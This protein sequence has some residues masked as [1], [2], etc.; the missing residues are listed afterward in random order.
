MRIGFSIFQLIFWNYLARILL[1]FWSGSPEQVFLG[2]FS[3]SVEYVHWWA[4][5]L[6][7]SSLR[8]TMLLAQSLRT[9]FARS[10]FQLDYAWCVILQIP[11]PKVYWIRRCFDNRGL[12]PYSDS[13]VE[14]RFLCV[15][16]TFIPVMSSWE[17]IITNPLRPS[18]SVQQ[19][20]RCLPQTQ[21]TMCCLATRWV[22]ALISPQPIPP[23]ACSTACTAN[24]LFFNF[25]Y[26][27][28]IVF[29]LTERF[30]S[31]YLEHGP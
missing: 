9:Q 28:R 14:L 24:G 29:P 4:A 15:T 20:T 3:I 13:R 16:A 11:A 8:A 19:F 6:L 18:S 26:T 23:V 7:R 30:I 10:Q 2:M 17:K 12:K 5:K 22:H 27:L 21:T 25:V 31:S 1:R